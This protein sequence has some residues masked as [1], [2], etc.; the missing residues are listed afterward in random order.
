MSELETPR[1]EQFPDVASHRTQTPALEKLFCPRR[2]GVVQK[3]RFCQSSRSIIA[4][5]ARKALVC[6]AAIALIAWLWPSLKPSD[7]TGTWLADEDRPGQYKLR[8]WG[9]GNLEVYRYTGSPPDIPTA[10]IGWRIG[11]SGTLILIFTPRYVPFVSRFFGIPA[12]EIRK[13]L[14]GNQIGFQK[15][16]DPIHVKGKKIN[17]IQILHRVPLDGLKFRLEE[18]NRPKKLMIGKRVFSQTWATK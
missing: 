14:T 11:K 4:F 15:D 5:L 17:G 7:L 18:D 9:D 6:G 10:K 12:E 16:K 2:V 13:G 1:E 3:C 8:F